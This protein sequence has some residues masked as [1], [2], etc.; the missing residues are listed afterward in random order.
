MAGGAPVLSELLDLQFLSFFDTLVDDELRDRMARMKIETNEFGYDR[1]GACP[2]DALRVLALVRW[3]YRHYFR[4]TVHGLENIPEG[5][6]LLIGNH[7][8]QLA[9]DGML[10][11]A[12]LALEAEPPRFVRA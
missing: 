5:R 8:S 9:Y 7:S 2:R 4:V 12:A 1:W 6:V 11:G 10:V 3:L